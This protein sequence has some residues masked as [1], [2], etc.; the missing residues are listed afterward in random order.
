[1]G[2]SA[3]G[4]PGH[5]A[6]AWLLAVAGCLAGLSA[7]ARSPKQEPQPAPAPKLTE[8]P[9]DQERDY[10]G[11]VH[12][13][14]LGYSAQGDYARAEPLFQK[15]RALYDEA[16]PGGSAR[17]AAVLNDLAALYAEAGDYAEAER[18]MGQVLAIRAQTLGKKHADYGAALH[19]LGLLYE[20]T[21]RRDQAETLLRQDLE[22]TR[23]A[24]GPDHPDYAHSLDSLAYLY[25]QTGRSAQAEPLYRQALA[26]LR[27]KQGEESRDVARVL[28]NLGILCRQ[29]G[30]LEEAERLLV[31]SRD[32][33]RLL[34]GPNHPDCADSQADLAALYDARHDYPRALEALGEA[35]RISRAGL[36]AASLAQS[37][38]RQLAMATAFRGRLDDYLG[39]ALRAQAPAARAYEEVVRWKGSVFARRRHAWTGRPSP[40]VDALLRQLDAAAGRLA[41]L[42]FST[43][44]DVDAYRRWSVQVQEASRQQ[45]RLEAELVRLNG[46][47]H[48]QTGLS[49]SDQV[50]AAIPSGA[51]LL[52]Y[53]EYAP[54]DPS[55]PAGRAGPERRL[56]VFTVRAGRPLEFHDL[57]PA[58]RVAAAVGRWRARVQRLTPGAAAEVDLRRLILDPVG[59]ALQGAR[60][61]LV[62]PDGDV[63]RV[64]FAAL[65]GSR[66]DSY[67]LEEMSVAV[68]P[69]PR[70]LAPSAPSAASSGGQESGTP[71]LLLV[72]DVDFGASP[73][74]GTGPP[75]SLDRG[76][77]SI[78]FEP[79]PATRGEILAIRDSFEEQYGH[80]GV[81]TLRGARADKRAVLAELPRHRW[82]HLA[83]HG[84]FASEAV[85][86]TPGASLAADSGPRAPSDPP[87]PPLPLDL[88]RRHPG[89]LSGLALARANANFGGG[90]LTALE[91]SDLDLAGVELVTLSACETGLGEAAGGEGVL[92]LQRAFQVAGARSV[93]A[94]LW[95]V[96]DD[97]T[98]KLM[99]R[100]Y[101]NLW[102]K[103]LPKVLALRQAQLE[104]LRE[105]A[106][107]SLEPAE[108]PPRSSRP[109]SPASWAAFVLS[110][111]WR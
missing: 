74:P 100:F 63:A 107:R 19:N 49:R 72:G 58:Q 70:L 90:V 34:L 48:G 67:L 102:Q 65:P 103:R 83:T 87:V 18:L 27:A 42:A 21:N 32:L 25:A 20:K 17:Y 38:R 105:E 35:V 33:R 12:R 5:R 6:S 15:A 93:V 106:G 52:D 61:L 111:D 57:G 3:P 73:R 75:G 39:L 76:L 30:R 9:P 66:P 109:A 47:A 60:L 96:P 104:V 1:M 13:L 62:S 10:A 98:R 88:R 95:K 91:V 36:E 86:T 37:E 51:V 44:A 24:R 81:Q 8:L 16:D 110:G 46:Q 108:G 28:D 84:F 29:V 71:S 26:I 40:R 50:Q 41:E 78:R 53:L 89:L 7:D 45:E 68:V 56:A 14:A 97:A 22:I 11:D 59:P 55:Q 94:S 64:P 101:T 85:P 54:S 92:G 43:P 4:R 77:A 82:L 69:V 79:L 2:E 23:A 31:R 80:D 99:E